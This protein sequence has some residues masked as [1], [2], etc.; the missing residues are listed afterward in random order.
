MACQLSV[1]S[2]GI[3]NDGRRVV[4]KKAL[5]ISGRYLIILLLFGFAVLKFAPYRGLLRQN[6]QAALRR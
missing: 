5:R 2:W 1:E 3:L 4:N 6:N